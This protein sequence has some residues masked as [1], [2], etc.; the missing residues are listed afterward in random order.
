MLYMMF[1]QIEYNGME[2]IVYEDGTIIQN[3]TKK[4]APFKQR[5][6]CSSIIV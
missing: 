6:I 5:W 3:D 1:K 4:K 2:C